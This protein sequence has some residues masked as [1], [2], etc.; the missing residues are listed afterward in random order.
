MKE[1]KRGEESVKKYENGTDRVIAQLQRDHLLQPL[2]ATVGHGLKL[3][4]EYFLG[5]EASILGEVQR[6]EDEL[7]TRNDEGL[8]RAGQPLS[9]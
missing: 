6:K 3:V 2:K 9:C 5:I 4:K 8:I 7:K 1:E